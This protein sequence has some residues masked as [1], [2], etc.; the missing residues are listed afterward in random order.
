MAGE[1][2]IHFRKHPT[3]SKFQNNSVT[4]EQNF[5]CLRLFNK[6]PTSL[7]SFRNF[8]LLSMEKI[9]VGVILLSWW[10]KIIKSIV[11]H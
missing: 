2:L 8:Y 5:S 7:F 1:L 3:Q 10:L 9:G 6:R 11:L 4:N